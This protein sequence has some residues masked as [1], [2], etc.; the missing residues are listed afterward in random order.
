MGEVY[1]AEDA[2]L[3][4]SV[5]LK[6]LSPELAADATGLR[7]FLREARTA[8]SLSHPNVVS[9]FEVGEDQGTHFIAMEYVTGATLREEIAKGPLGVDD[10]IAITR[11]IANALS[12]AQ[13]AGIVHRDIKPENI[14]LTG[15]R[16]VK[17]LDFGLAVQHSP[18]IE[19]FADVTRTQIT[20]QGNIVG[21][22]RYMSPEQ[23]KGK[24]ADARSDIF[25]LGLVMYEMLAGK[26][27][28]DGGT[29]LQYVSRVMHDAPDALARFNYAV[30]ESLDRIVRKCIEKDPDWRYQSA[31]ELS[32]DLGAVERHASIAIR[33]PVAKKRWS[34][35]LWPVAASLICASIFAA[36]LIAWLLLRPNRLDSVAVLPFSNESGD[37]SLD[38]AA[39]GLPES[40]QRDLARSPN[41]KVAAWTLTRRYRGVPQNASA[42]VRDL[43]VQT[44]VTGTLNRSGSDVRL[45]VE[46]TTSQGVQLW[47]QQYERPR[48]ELINVEEAV[49]SDV[50][51]RL[52]PKVDRGSPGGGRRTSDSQAYDLYLRGRFS[53]N[54]RTATDLQTAVTQFRNATA[55]DQSYALAHSGLADAYA[56][57]ANYGIQPPVTI[58]PLAKTEARRAIELDPEL[59]EAHNSNAVAVAFSDFDW[60]GA[61]KSFRR[62]LQ[63]NPNYAQAHTWFALMLLTPL[64]RYEEALIEI[65]RAIELEPNEPIFQHSHVLILYFSRHFEEALATLH[66]VNPSYLPAARAAEEAMCL[67]ALGRRD[68]A[69]AAV[70]GS[71]EAGDQTAKFNRSM[72]AYSYAVAGRRRDAEQIA[73]ELDAEARNVYSSACSRSAIQVA[74]GNTNRALNLLQQCYDDRDFDFRFSGVD[75]RFDALRSDSRFSA[76]LNKAGLR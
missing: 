52:S 56:L 42:F 62:A 49:L 32:I 34:R 57:M 28:F 20:V 31:R 7:R 13:A 69:V 63:L 71:G 23:L 74:L 8:A 72:L 43:H 30:P 67:A 51:S 75:A 65:R 76:L 16:H 29:G 41:L 54:R 40:L 73:S 58:L 12:A 14:I 6:V 18:V 1:L 27:P 66:R 22:L 21:T 2:N 5:A 37:P 68:Q 55:K 25:A 39:D 24:A 11:Q 4:R 10:A 33:A 38:Y 3:P 50:N 46:L 48:T 60:L 35:L 59:A 61:E 17:V 26:R 15:Q 19:E 45:N 64:K 47:A 9:V 36:A 44:Y 70:T 53:L